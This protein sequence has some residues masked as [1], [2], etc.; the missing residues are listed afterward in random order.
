MVKKATPADLGQ[1]VR[2]I[3]D[4]KITM[5]EM[6]IDQWQEGLPDTPLITADIKNGIGYVVRRGREVLG[7]AALVFDPD[8]VY[9]T[10]VGKFG[11][12]GQP[13]ATI[14]RVATCKHAK[15]CGIASMLFTYFEKICKK[16]GTKWLRIYTHADNVPMKNLC[17]KLGYQNVGV[18]DYKG[19][20]RDT[21]EKKL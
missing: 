3:E 2:I 13:Y 6:G 1:I 21:F 18:V 15:K 7:Y 17:L 14:R 12:Q 8:P 9:D 20:P 5:R 19:A 4:A 11:A 10:L 16:H